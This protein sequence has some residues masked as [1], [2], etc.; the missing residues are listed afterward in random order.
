MLTWFLKV[1]ALN[2]VWDL[3]NNSLHNVEALQYL[4]KFKN[5]W[6]LRIKLLMYGL[7]IF[8]PGYICFLYSILTFL[9]FLF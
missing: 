4:Q 7:T 3:V 1:R 5:I 6:K 2:T 8:H 9:W